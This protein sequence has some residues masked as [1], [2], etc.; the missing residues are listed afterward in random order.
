MGSSAHYGS[1]WSQLM[2]GHHLNLGAK[3]FCLSLL[4]LFFIKIEKG[5]PNAL[6]KAND[7]GEAT[8]TL[9]FGC[10]VCIIIKRGQSPLVLFLYL[11]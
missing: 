5:N 6:I 4:I 8:F 10:V 9:D 1:C 11:V 3:A 7:V 2:V